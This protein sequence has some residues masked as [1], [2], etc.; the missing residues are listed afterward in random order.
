MRPISES[1]VKDCRGGK[2]QTFQLDSFSVATPAEHRGDFFVFAQ[3]L[4]GEQ[5]LESVGE[6]FLSGRRG[7][8]NFWTRFE[9]FFGSFFLTFFK[10]FFVS[11]PRGSTGVQRYGCIPQSAANNL[12]EFPQKLGAP[13]P[14][15]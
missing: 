9:S 6:L 3:I 5:F 13:N 2:T 11:W 1:I 12:G 10:P 15:F 8:K 7:A 14:L 4:G